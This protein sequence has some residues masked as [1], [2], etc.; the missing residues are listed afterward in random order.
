MILVLIELGY[1]NINSPR[2]TNISIAMCRIEVNFN[3][4]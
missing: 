3:D 4:S 1:Y 2:I